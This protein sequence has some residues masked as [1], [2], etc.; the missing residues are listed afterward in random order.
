M[1]R[2]SWRGALARGRRALSQR[3]VHWAW[4]AAQRAGAVTVD[5][6]AGRGFAAFG[7]GSI[8][9]FPPGAIFGERWIEVG[10]DTI[11]GKHVTMSAG[12]VPGQDLGAVPLL[13]IGDRCVIGRGTHI[14]AHASIVIGDDV[15][16]GPYVYITDQNHGYADPEIPIGRQWPANAAVSIGA[17]SWLGA[18]AIVLPGASIGRNV[19]VAAGSVVRGRVPD[20]CVVAGVPAKVIRSYVAGDGWLPPRSDGTR[21]LPADTGEPAAGPG[22]LIAGFADP[23]LTDPGLADAGLADAGVAETGPLADAQRVE[24]ITEPPDPVF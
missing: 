9:A 15:Y 5:T 17:G 20:R 13:R 11:V 22:P 6:P 16:T 3:A 18:G 1:S 19:V 4:Q 23:G 12:T 8:L 21:P 7:R 14:V 24:G 10:A 2:V